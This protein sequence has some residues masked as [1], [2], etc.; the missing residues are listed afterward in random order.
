MDFDN[1]EKNFHK[2]FGNLILTDYQVEV[3]EK[4][5][6]NYNDFNNLNELIYYLED[7]LNNSSNEELELISD[8]LSEFNYYNYTNK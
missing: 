1:L 7:Y 3:L 2:K 4:Y 6:I 5:N 8:E